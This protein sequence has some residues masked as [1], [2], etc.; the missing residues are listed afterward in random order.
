M[1]ITIDNHKLYEKLPE[2]LSDQ[3]PV[4]IIFPD[5]SFP[6][7]W[8]VV[9]IDRGITIHK[10]MTIRFT[11]LCKYFVLSKEDKNKKP[12]TDNVIKLAVN[13]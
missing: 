4:Y 2:S 12:I 8:G 9:D 3:E 1:T 10:N 7:Q 11:N 13:K 5:N 6:A